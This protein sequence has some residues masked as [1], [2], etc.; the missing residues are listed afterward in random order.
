MAIQ[1]QIIPSDGE[2]VYM[3]LVTGLAIGAGFC[4]CVIW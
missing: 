4:R 2:Y 1:K 3:L